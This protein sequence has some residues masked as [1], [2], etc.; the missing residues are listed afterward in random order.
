M[1]DQ[2]VLIT[3]AGPQ[4]GTPIAEIFL[5]ARAAMTYLP[6]LHTQAE[7]RAFIQN[8]VA[9]SEVWVAK[10]DNAIAG[11]ASLSSTHLDHLYVHPALHHHGLGSLLLDRVK[12]QH[13][14]GFGLW[15]FQQNKAAR[16]FYERHGLVLDHLT[17]GADNEENLPD[18]FYLW[19]P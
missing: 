7:T 4:D 16:R 5:A 14:A 12:T 6:T 3:R 17:D 1:T 11:F 19:R 18:A 8:L 9:T 13:P 10:V 2:T 15:T